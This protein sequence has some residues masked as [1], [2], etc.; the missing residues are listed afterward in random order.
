[1]TSSDEFGANMN[2]R[3]CEDDECEDKRD[4]VVRVRYDQ[5]LQSIRF[6]VD[7]DSLP[8]DNL[9]GYE[10]ISKFTVKYQNDERI[11]VPYNTNSTFYTDSNGLEMQKRILNFRP[12]WDL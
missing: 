2:F 9:H 1:M 3:Y 12:T 6:E 5:D 7:L 11:W 10:I 8:Q 4:A